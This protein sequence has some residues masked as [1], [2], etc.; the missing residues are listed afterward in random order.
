MYPEDI[1][2]PKNIEHET[3]E[4][5]LFFPKMSALRQ[6]LFFH[7]VAEEDL[8]FSLLKRKSIQAARE[9]REKG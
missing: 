3:G 9:K 6:Q 7:A 1:R 2:V 4:W 5:P 8:L